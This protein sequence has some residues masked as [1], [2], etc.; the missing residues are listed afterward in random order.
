MYLKLDSM[1]FMYC[2]NCGKQGHLYSEC[3][4]PITSYGVIVFRFNPYI[5][6]NEYLMVCRNNSFGFIDF[7]RGKYSINNKHYIK[8]MVKQMTVQEKHDLKTMEFDELWRKLWNIPKVIPEL[9]QEEEEEEAMAMAAAAETSIAH[10]YKTISFSNNTRTFGKTKHTQDEVYRNEELNSMDKFNLLKNGVNFVNVS[11]TTPANLHSEIDEIDRV[12]SNTRMGDQYSSANFV[13]SEHTTC[14]PYS[15]TS[16]IDECECYEQWDEPEWGFP[17]GRRNNQ[18]KDYETAVREFSEETGVLSRYLRNI[19][20]IYPF[21]ENIMG[22]NYKSYKHKYY[23]MCIDYGD[24]LK[25]VPF[26]KG[27]VSKAEWKTYDDC[28]QCIRFYNLEKKRIILNIH[29]CLTK[30]SLYM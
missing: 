11:S 9:E 8:N 3:K 18:E 10:K 13:D 26:E 28:I 4:V 21:E 14:E 12:Y 30:Y 23:L 16:I 17:K 22:S 6:E 5:G 2:N 29:Q 25:T 15:I 24:S 7:M 27:E 1:N 20:N 19:Q